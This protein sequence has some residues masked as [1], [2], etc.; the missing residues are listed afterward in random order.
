MT[1]AAQC[2]GATFLETEIGVQMTDDRNQIVNWEW[3]K[4]L[5]NVQHSTSNHGYYLIYKRISEASGS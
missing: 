3:E 5:M 1:H 4:N 2:Q